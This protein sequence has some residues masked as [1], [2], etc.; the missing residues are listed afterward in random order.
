MIRSAIIGTSGLVTATGDVGAVARRASAR[1]GATRDSKA[2]L[3]DRSFHVT[4]RR[5][6]VRMS[7]SP[8]VTWQ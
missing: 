4:S 7:S 3:T 6:A 8:A 2:F 5:L 1:A